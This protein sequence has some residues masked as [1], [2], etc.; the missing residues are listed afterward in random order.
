MEGKKYIMNFIQPCLHQFVIG[1]HT[2]AIVFYG[3]YKLIFCRNC[4]TVHL[5]TT[6]QLLNKG[7]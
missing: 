7:M 6:G 3:I 4:R 1:V 2:I 5:L